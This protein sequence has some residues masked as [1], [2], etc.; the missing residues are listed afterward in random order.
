MVGLGK[1]FEVFDARLSSKRW[2]PILVDGDLLWVWKNES[3]G[4][5][6]PL[7]FLAHQRRRLFT[8][9]SVHYT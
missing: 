2:M 4:E 1:C 8:S 3:S 9:E 7:P 6:Q 5:E